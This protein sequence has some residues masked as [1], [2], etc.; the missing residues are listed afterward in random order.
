MESGTG[1]LN[2]LPLSGVLDRLAEKTPAPGAGSTAA[3][4]CSLAAALLEMTAAFDTTP[5]GSACGVR[6]GALRGRALELADRELH[7]YEPVL[8]ALRV[9]AS[10]PDREA[11][12]ASAMAAASTA[13]LA[14]AS[15]AA[16]L[17]GIA[18]ET[19][20][21]VSDQLVG[22]AVVAS[23][24]AEGACRAAARLVQ[25]NLAGAAGDPRLTEVA[26]L[27]KAAAEARAETLA[28]ASA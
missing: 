24:L 14:I 5:M 2:D 25:I 22:E 13:P 7:T 27:V 18:A 1:T 10:D 28:K 26:G 12:L 9:P 17:A 8:E 3:L 15:V 4:V 6:A 19:V 16:Q 11:R 21:G 23:E 20:D